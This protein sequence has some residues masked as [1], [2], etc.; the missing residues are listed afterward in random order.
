M[1]GELKIKNK[2]NQGSNVIFLQIYVHITVM[3][4][5]S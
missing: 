2:R 1:L 5:Y 3:K 4:N